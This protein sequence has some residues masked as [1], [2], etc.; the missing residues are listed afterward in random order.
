MAV[1]KS[2]LKRYQLMWKPSF[3]YTRNDDSGARQRMYIIGE[4]RKYVGDNLETSMQL[5]EGVSQDPDTFSI[6][7]ILRVAYNSTLVIPFNTSI[8]L[9]Q[10]YRPQIKNKLVKYETLGGNSVT[11]F[12][13]AIKEVNLRIKII[14]AGRLWETYEKGLEA[15]SYLS[16]NQGRYYGAVY[17]LGYDMFKDGTE[18]LVGRYQVTIDSLDFSHRSSENTTLNADLK[19]TVLHDY[20]NYQSQKHRVWGS[21]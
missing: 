11:T 21:L 15:I 3:P 18:S 9:A 1:G 14:K 8:A 4:K 5:E 17:L 19:M 13:Q 2:Q 10:E 16:A 6:Q 20:G 12:G 7:E